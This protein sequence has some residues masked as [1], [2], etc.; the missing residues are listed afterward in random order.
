MKKK[1]EI[2]RYVCVPRR[3]WPQSSSLLRMVEGEGEGGEVQKRTTCVHASIAPAML[4]TTDPI[5]KHETLRTERE[6]G[7]A[8]K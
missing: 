8:Y 2:K 6:A 4:P 1:T 5:L 3:S 7:Y